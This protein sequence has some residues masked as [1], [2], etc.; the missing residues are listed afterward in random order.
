MIGAAIASKIISADVGLPGSPMTGF[1]PAAARTVG[2]PGL[3]PKPVDDDPG[4]PERSHRLRG[5][6]PL[7]DRGAAREHDRIAVGQSRPQRGFE[8][9]G[10]V[11]DGRIVPH[12]CAHHAQRGRDGVAIRIAHFSRPRPR[13]RRTNSSPLEIMAMTGRRYTGTSTAPTVAST[14]I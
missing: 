1:P 11:G 5:A 12:R 4:R 2:F 10:I 7:P 9:S 13:G 3:H 6:I 8:G 14:P